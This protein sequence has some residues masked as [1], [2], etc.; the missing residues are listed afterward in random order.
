[1]RREV[2]LKRRDKE[3]LKNN[4]TVS[5]TLLIACTYSSA[6]LAFATFYCLLQEVMH[7]AG[8][9]YGCGGVTPPEILFKA[10]VGMTAIS[11]GRQKYF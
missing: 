8:R 3:Q 5:N 4:V 9:R 11:V 10:S 2:S 1:M 7:R 6:T